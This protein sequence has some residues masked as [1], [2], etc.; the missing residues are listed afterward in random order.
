MI[1][2]LSV[3]LEMLKTSAEYRYISTLP[4]FSE[5][6]GEFNF[7]KGLNVI[8]APNGHGKTT[9]MNMLKKA[10]FSG[11][12]GH[13]VF[14]K[15]ELHSKDF[16]KKIEEEEYLQ[17]KKQGDLFLFSFANYESFFS[18]AHDGQSVIYA[19]PKF[20]EGSDEDSMSS[21]SHKLFS[22]H[23]HEKINLCGSTGKKTMHR[24]RNINDALEGNSKISTEIP[25]LVKPESLT[26]STFRRYELDSINYQYLA[27]TIERGQRT[28]LIDE[29]ES[30]LDLV[31]LFKWFSSLEEKIE[32]NNVQ[33]IMVSHSERVLN[34]KNAHYISTND[35]LQQ[36]RNLY[37]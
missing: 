24:M 3:N 8:L 26:S 12:F 37:K 15:D 35:Y 1:E 9:L 18:V 4:L 19:N 32:K 29:P 2:K 6:N 30:G 11:V 17:R 27:A 10:T 14:D 7:Q 31:E 25:V 16:I 34:F 36:C 21:F 20:I 23:K 22:I 5:Y 13:S 28:L 33:V